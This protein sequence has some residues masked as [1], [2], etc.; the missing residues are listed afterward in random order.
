MERRDSRKDSA[1]LLENDNRDADPG[2]DRATSVRLR[3]GVAA[4]GT[5]RTHR[6]SDGALSPGG[7]PR[8]RGLETIPPFL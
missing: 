2:R 3:D 1:G 8:V 6:T 4:D 5:R 7:R